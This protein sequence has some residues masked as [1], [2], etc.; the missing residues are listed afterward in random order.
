MFKVEHLTDMYLSIKG[1]E[2]K[3]CKKKKKKK[4]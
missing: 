4:R 3:F 1:D 2:S